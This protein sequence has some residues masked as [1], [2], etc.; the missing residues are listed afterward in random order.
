MPF[1]T[2]VVFS[3]Q[4]FNTTTYFLF[5]I[6]FNSIGY[7]QS[8]ELNKIISVDIFKELQ[9]G[10]V[11][12]IE[13]GNNGLFLSDHQN[14][15]VVK[16]QINQKGETLE[17][18][19]LGNKGR[20]P[21]EFS[22][23]PAIISF[24]PSNSTLVAQDL[25]SNRIVF[26]T[27]SSDVAGIEFKTEYTAEYPVT[28]L[29]F[30]TNGYLIYSTPLYN[31]EINSIYIRDNNLNLKYSFGVKASPKSIA[32]DLFQVTPF[33]QNKWVLVSFIFRNKFQIYDYQGNLIK[34]FKINSIP[35]V[36][37]TYERRENIELPRT[38]LISDIFIDEND[39][40]LFL[41]GSASNVIHSY[42][43]IDIFNSDGEKIKSFLLD[44]QA[45]KLVIK[46]KYLYTLS[47]D[48]DKIFIYDSNTLNIE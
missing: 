46:N 21:G 20:G 3:K 25:T 47:Y 45:R 44:E 17:L 41:I 16:F 22:S 12:D 28:D 39:N 14:F 40:I 9:T 6:L 31:G 43:L 32:F 48:R 30:T 15:N 42:K 13:T 24:C 19:R 4:I 23:G 35:T 7:S 5:L 27:D 18:Y 10:T 37:E 29:S 38:R 34:E 11:L 36:S 26:F 33:H 2:Y 1:M 8:T